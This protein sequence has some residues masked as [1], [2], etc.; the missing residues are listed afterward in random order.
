MTNLPMLREAVANSDC[1]RRDGEGRYDAEE[2]SRAARNVILAA[3]PALLD[4]LETLKARTCK[5][6]LQRRASQDWCFLSRRS[7]KTMG[8]TCGAWQQKD[9]GH[10]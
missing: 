2:R 5:T 8:F 4:E 10:P 1:R 9:E 3:A 6:C 7:C